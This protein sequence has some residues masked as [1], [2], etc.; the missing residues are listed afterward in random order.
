MRECEQTFRLQTTPSPERSTRPHG[1]YQQRNPA[2]PRHP[3]NPRPRLKDDLLRQMAECEAL[4]YRSIKLLQALHARGWSCDIRWKEGRAAGM[5]WVHSSGARIRG[6][7]I[8][9]SVPWLRSLGGIP[10]LRCGRMLPANWVPKPIQTRSD[11]YRIKPPLPRTLGS[12]WWDRLASW[13]WQVVTG[14]PAIPD[15]VIP[16]PMNTP[17]PRPDANRTG[18]DRTESPQPRRRR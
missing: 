9:R 17:R 15:P 10:G 7:K 11:T 4:G 2:P 8:G 16:P 13:A 18:I 1:R 5:T 6:A 12:S 14:N 3:Q